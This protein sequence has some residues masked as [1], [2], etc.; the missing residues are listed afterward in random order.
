LSEDKAVIRVADFFTFGEGPF[1]VIYDYTCGRKRPQH[2]AAG[3]VLP[4]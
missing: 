4:Y 3:G 2:Y 1:D